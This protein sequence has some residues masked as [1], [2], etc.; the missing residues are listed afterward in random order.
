MSVG[1]YNE[2]L[3]EMKK[4]FLV[5]DYYIYAVEVTPGRYSIRNMYY[6]DKEDG[7]KIQDRE[8]NKP[9][10]LFEVKK[11]E[12]V[13]I[14]D[15]YGKCIRKQNVYKYDRG[16]MTETIDWYYFEGYRE[17]FKSTTFLLNKIYQTDP[18]IRWL[19]AREIDLNKEKK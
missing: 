16:T 1:L 3:M 13:Y 7:L 10:Y 18:L 4:I 17:L 8:E 9:L 6:G 14:G 12:A 11:G 15:Y 19:D 2:D 5:G